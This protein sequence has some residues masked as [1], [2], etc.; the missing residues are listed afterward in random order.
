[1]QLST[2]GSSWIANLTMTSLDCDKGDGYK[3]M[4]HI[5]EPWFGYIVL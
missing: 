5:L 2:I 4:S 3:T 1:M